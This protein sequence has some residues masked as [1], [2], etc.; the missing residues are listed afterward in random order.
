MWRGVLTEAGGE[1]V[2]TPEA[3]QTQTTVQ[4]RV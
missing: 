2:Q 4:F 3:L 1:L